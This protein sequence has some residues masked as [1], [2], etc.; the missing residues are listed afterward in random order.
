MS[1]VFL[2]LSLLLL[3][4][5]ASQA[6]AQWWRADL[7]L[8]PRFGGPDQVENLL[9]NDQLRS[10]SWKQELR[11]N[12]RLTFGADYTA[13]FLSANDTSANDT[14]AGGIARAYGALGFTE[15]GT[16]IVKFEYRHNFGD[17]SP[18]VFG[19]TE[20]GYAGIV[21]RPFTDQEFGLH[22]LYWRQQ[23]K[24]GRSALLVGL[25]DTTDFV[26]T[27]GL[28]SPFL[29]FLNHSFGAGSST[30]GMPND[31]AFGAAYGTMLR[32]NFYIIGSLVD[33]N[34]DPSEPFKGVENFL[35]DFELFKSIE[36]GWISSRQKI[37]F[38]SF[39]FTAWH[40]DSQTDRNISEGYG[41]NFSLSRYV[42]KNFM[43]F[44]RG[45]YAKDGGSLLTKSLSIG[46]GYQTTAF[47]GMFGA[48]LNWGDPNEDTFDQGLQDQW[49]LEIF[50]RV[51]LGRRFA[52][53][54]DIQYIKDPAL[55][56]SED[57]IWMF[58][59]RGRAAF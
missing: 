12:H 32:D 33:A 43:P 6:H 30:I 26:D 58:N 56:L 10:S 51:P 47:N 15:K 9:D 52:V 36:G 22:N 34:G 37:L 45:G 27:Y 59:L 50:F 7:A 49:A 54:G 17:P 31:A 18:A 14:A 21:G 23:F 48:G 28:A 8:E 11:D 38:D 20:L 4:L 25:L 46:L 57:T 41:F 24:G 42:N 2:Q 29:H 35:S 13:V 19:L 53:T 44:V 5:L 3:L 1:R 55:N 16:L 40:K 39:H